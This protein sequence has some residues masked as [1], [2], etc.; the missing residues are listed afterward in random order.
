MILYNKMFKIITG[1]PKIL[2]NFV[3]NFIKVL[4]NLNYNEK[5]KK[6]NAE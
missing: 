2:I 5:K 4:E 3:I 1:S 6:K